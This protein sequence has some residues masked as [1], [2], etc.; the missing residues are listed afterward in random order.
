MDERGEFF[1]PALKFAVVSVAGSSTDSVLVS[2]VA[3]KKIRVVSYELVASAGTTVL[4][5][6]GTTTALSGTMS[7]AANG[8]IDF[9]GSADAPG[10]E[11]IAGENLVVTTGTGA[12]EGHLCYVEVA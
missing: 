2:G 1:V 12:I 9:A 10:F 11:T 5:E 3:G 8:T 6:S 7:L 4:F